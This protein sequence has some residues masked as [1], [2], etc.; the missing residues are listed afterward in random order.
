MPVDVGGFRLSKQMENYFSPLGSSSSRAAAS[1]QELISNGITQDGMYW[2]NL[3]Q[4]G[5]TYTYCDLTSDSIGWM[6]L[7][8]N[9]STIPLGSQP[10]RNSVADYGASSAFWQ[11]NLGSNQT[12]TF[13]GYQQTTA[14]AEKL[15]KYMP[16]KKLRFAGSTYASIMTSVAADYFNYNAHQAYKFSTAIFIANSGTTTHAQKMT[17]QESWTRSTN[18]KFDLTYNQSW[19]EGYNAGSFLLGFY[20]IVASAYGDWQHVYLGGTSQRRSLSAALWRNRSPE[21]S[22]FLHDNPTSIDCSMGT[23][24]HRGGGNHWNDSV[25]IQQNV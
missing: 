25:W 18:A 4:L 2:I 10:P 19:N 16:Y 24:Y 3:P 9:D 13:N 12:Y 1:T 20:R 8:A 11:G 14:T 17:A 5:P 21:L 22:A 15:I 23:S 6:L 7:L